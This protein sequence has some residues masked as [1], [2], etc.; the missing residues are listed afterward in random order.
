MCL[1]CRAKEGPRRQRMR[2][3]RCEQLRPLLEPEL[4][5]APHQRWKATRR[6]DMEVKCHVLCEARRRVTGIRRLDHPTEGG[7]GGPQLIRRDATR[8]QRRRLAFE[9]E[10][11]LVQGGELGPIRLRHTHAAIRLRLEHALRCQPLQCLADR[12]RP[13]AE[14]AADRAD[15]NCLT[16]RES[17]AHQQGPDLGIGPA[18]EGLRN[19]RRD[20]GLSVCGDSHS[21]IKE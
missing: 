3:R 5:N 6:V 20:S 15:G 14:L 9:D 8:G 12:G 21:F 13:D 17:A 2:R 1:S 18:A 4:F 19:R 7:A 10:A 16:G 11:G